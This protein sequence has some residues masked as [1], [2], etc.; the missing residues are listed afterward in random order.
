[1]EIRMGPLCFDHMCV[2]ADILDEVLLGEDLLLCDPSGPAD[3]IQSEEKM[4]FRGVSIPLMMVSP[5]VVRHV[6]VAEDVEVPAMQE[7]IVDVFVDRLENQ[8]EDEVGRLLV[9]MHPNLPEGYGCILAPM[10][11]DASSNTT[12][13][14]CILNPHSYPIVVRQDSVVSQVEP[15]DVVHTISE[16]ENPSEKSNCSATRRVLLGEKSMLPGKAHRV[17]KGQK[18]SFAQYVQEPLAHSQHTLKDLYEHSVKGRNEYQK[19]VIHWLLL[20][21]QNVFSKNENDLG[22]THLVEHTIK[23]GNARPIKQQPR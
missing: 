18:R 2:V 8:N 7:V 16:C 14:V 23:T 19:K 4:V 22:C 9:E 1:M 20:K 15:V 11:V 13:T 12:V 17:T 6:T 21:H 3:I 5:S 10:I